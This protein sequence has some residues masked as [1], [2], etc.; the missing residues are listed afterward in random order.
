MM[1]DCGPEVPSSKRVM[2]QLFSFLIT[3]VQGLLC[4]L[5]ENVSVEG[6]VPLPLLSEGLYNLLKSRHIKFNRFQVL[7]KCITDESLGVEGIL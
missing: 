3:G 6:S 1:A 7:P 4:G 5:N 2:E